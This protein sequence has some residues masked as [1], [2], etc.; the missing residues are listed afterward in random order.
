MLLEAST[1]KCSILY[2]SIDE[3][4]PAAISPRG[5]YVSR[6]M[7]P[8]GSTSEAEKEKDRSSGAT[9]ATAC[10]D[11]LSSSTDS[12]RGYDSVS[13]TAMLKLEV[14]ERDQRILELEAAL[15][16]QARSKSPTW[17]TSESSFAQQRVA[18]VAAQHAGTPEWHPNAGGFSQT[19]ASGVQSSFVSV[20]PLPTT[21]QTPLGFDFHEGSYGV[22][23]TPPCDE[24]QGPGTQA[25]CEEE[26]RTSGTP[27]SLVGL[28]A[29]RPLDCESTQE[30]VGA[31]DLA[32]HDFD[33]G[34]NSNI[35]APAHSQDA[36]MPPIPL[37]PSTVEQSR[38]TGVDPDNS[39]ARRG[40]DSAAL[41]DASSDAV[42]LALVPQG[43]WGGD[44]DNS[45]DGENKK[46]IAMVKVEL[47]LGIPFES[48][49]GRE[50]EFKKVLCGDVAEALG[51]DV[52]KLHLLDMQPGSIVATLGLEPG[53][54]GTDFAVHDVASNLAKHARDPNSELRSRRRQVSSAVT[55]AT[56]VAKARDPIAPQALDMP[57]GEEN[58]APYSSSSSKD[59]CIAT[60]TAATEGG[61]V[62][63]EVVHGGADMESARMPIAHEPA[64][65]NLAK[66]Q[67]TP[68][69]RGSLLAR[70]FGRAPRLHRA[71]KSVPNQGAGS[72]AEDTQ[73]GV[74]TAR[75]EAGEHDELNATRIACEGGVPIA[76]EQSIELEV[77]EL[78]CASV[79]SDSLPDSGPWE[80]LARNADTGAVFPAGSHGVDHR[81]IAVLANER[82]C[83][84]APSL[85]EE[86]LAF[87]DSALQQISRRKSRQ[88]SFDESGLAICQHE[89]AS[90][91]VNDGNQVEIDAQQ[92][93]IEMN[94]Q[95]NGRAA[96]RA[97]DEDDCTTSSEWPGIAV[98]PGVHGRASGQ[99]DEQTLETLAHIDR[100][101]VKSRDGEETTRGH[102]LEE[103]NDRSGQEAYD[104]SPLMRREERSASL[105][106]TS[107]S[108]VLN[109]LIGLVS[110]AS[111]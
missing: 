66:T 88:M 7:R 104:E 38:T 60:D 61:L 57:S 42:G 54:C 41:D 89:S 92:V 37:T 97:S 68:E 100:E 19:P 111:R 101:E 25:A 11:R 18:V 76:A 69:R 24:G 96:E 43:A 46:K 31:Q 91:R 98:S 64:E 67:T 50:E 22:G 23:G 8:L 53:V 3:V 4:P 13:A 71:S 15:Y 47:V 83:A 26:M 106:S 62:T 49:A 34:A 39:T 87:W 35:S 17:G 20:S 108:S 5:A 110:R 56:I 105:H 77:D 73:A 6:E 93:E 65:Q 21:I 79:P 81:D 107:P 80:C 30:A 84:S 51:A 85:P 27:K 16:D 94:A 63:A 86:N 95:V 32:P 45:Q 78:Y 55:G 59:T 48:I 10:L 14:K 44:C 75:I 70:I 1:E 40:D 12:M 82:L 103:D 102:D 52:A 33:F 9:A 36:P 58:A 99:A 74:D 28:R 29:F 72:R 90:N 2:H 109:P